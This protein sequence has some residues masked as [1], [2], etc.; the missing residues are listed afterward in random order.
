MKKYFEFNKPFIKFLPLFFIILTLLILL[1][2]SK[3]LLSNIIPKQDGYI[4]KTDNLKILF[5]NN[6]SN[7]FNLE[8]KEIEFKIKNISSKR[9][10]YNVYF[11]LNNDINK[12]KYKVI[13]NNKNYLDNIIGEDNYIDKFNTI[14]KYETISYKVKV[15]D[16][17]K[18]KYKIIVEES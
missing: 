18:D 10:T 15:N 2:N 3:N 9:I 8:N 5:L 14:N 6:N 17:Y 1:G 12:I 11:E 4:E 13:K 7:I 16:S